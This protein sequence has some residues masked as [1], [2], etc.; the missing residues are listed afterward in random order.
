MGPH[1]LEAGVPDARPPDM[2][3][4]D[5]RTTTLE[6]VCFVCGAHA[7]TLIYVAGEDEPLREEAACDVHARGHRQADAAASAPGGE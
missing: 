5:P 6:L 7:T 2:K 3:N 4:T 1:A